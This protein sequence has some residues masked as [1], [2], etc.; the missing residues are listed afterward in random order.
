MCHPSWFILSK[1]LLLC[2][3]LGYPQKCGLLTFTNTH[4]CTRTHIPEGA[5]LGWK[6]EV[7]KFTPASVRT[8]IYPHQGQWQQMCL[9]KMKKEQGISSERRLYSISR[10]SLRASFQHE[11]FFTFCHNVCCLLAIRNSILSIFSACP[12]DACLSGMPCLLCVQMLP[13]WWGLKVRT[14]AFFIFFFLN[15][16]TVCWWI[17]A[18]LAVTVVQMWTA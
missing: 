7:V 2:F 10:V 12:T 11:H 1:L 3:L 18:T 13:E 16:G 17:I 8:V 4:T 5:Q 14:P 9:D 15:P 6:Q